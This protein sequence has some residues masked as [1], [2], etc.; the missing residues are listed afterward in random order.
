[1][2]RSPDDA[3]WH[4]GKGA[5]KE[6]SIARCPRP[7]SPVKP[8]DDPLVVRRPLLCEAAEA[9]VSSV[10]ACVSRALLRPEDGSELPRAEGRVGAA[11]VSCAQR[12]SPRNLARARRRGHAG[13]VRSSIGWGTTPNAAATRTAADGE[14]VARV[15]SGSHAGV[16]SR[17]LPSLA[18]Q[19]P[20]NHWIRRPMSLRRAMRQL[21]PGQV[22]AHPPIHLARIHP[23]LPRP[24]LQPLP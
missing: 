17:R 20:A 18:P 3:R 23:P 6:E 10:G 7:A 4:G 9:E 15:G 24:R 8:P 1:M 19:P 14:P 11:L 22:P 13:V 5:V 12:L 21:R 2:Q 16:D